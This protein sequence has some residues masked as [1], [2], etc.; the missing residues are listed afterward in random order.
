[1]NIKENRYFS[2][3]VLMVNIYTSDLSPYYVLQFNAFYYN[4]NILYISI[5]FEEGKNPDLKMWVDDGGFHKSK[6]TLKTMYKVL[7]MIYE[8]LKYDTGN[9]FINQSN[10][11]TKQQKLKHCESSLGDSGG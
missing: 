6:L 1:M 5:S 8:Y 4:T 3:G 2:N 9:K 11:I 10:Y 7:D